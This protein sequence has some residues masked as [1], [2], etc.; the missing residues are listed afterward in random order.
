MA[1]I[2]FYINIGCLGIA[3][4]LLGPWLERNGPRKAATI[5]GSLFCFGH[6]VAALGI[7]LKVTPSTILQRWFALTF[8]FSSLHDDHFTLY[9]LPL[10]FLLCWERCVYDLCLCA[11]EYITA[12]S[13]GSSPPPSSLLMKH[14]H[15]RP[16]M[17][18]CVILHVITSCLSSLHTTNRHIDKPP[19]SQTVASLRLYNASSHTKPLSFIHTPNF[20][21]T[22]SCSLSL[23]ILWCSSI[24]L[25]SS[26][27][28]E[29]CKSE[30]ANV[31]MRLSFLF[32]HAYDLPFSLHS[33][34][35]LSFSDTESFQVLALDF[36][37]LGMVPQSLRHTTL[38]PSV[39]FPPLPIFSL[40][41][42]SS[43]SAL[44]SPGPWWA[45]LMMTRVPSFVP[46]PSSKY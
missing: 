28:L 2:T 39:P 27:S 44:S 46:H 18:A 6:W 33:R 10:F 25:F 34:S 24:D 17:S 4:S 23:S 14:E 21:Y 13:P 42:Y 11:F 40:F 37:T 19:Y 16:S 3:A 20:P 15:F 30:Y 9:S 35:L 41:S 1:P 31:P 45:L 7:Y 22:N 12:L 29:L 8:L 5:G 43:P 38:S 26:F 32:I 36:A